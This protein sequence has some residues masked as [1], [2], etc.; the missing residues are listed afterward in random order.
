MMWNICLALV[1]FSLSVHPL[2]VSQHLTSRQESGYL[3]GHF[4]IKKHQTIMAP[5][6]FYLTWH[7]QLMIHAKWEYVQLS[8]G[9]LLDTEAKHAFPL[10]AGP[11]MD[12]S[13][14][15]VGFVGGLLFRESHFPPEGSTF[16]PR[17]FYST[18]DDFGP[19]KRGSYELLPLLGLSLSKQWGAFEVSS[20]VNHKLVNVS[21]GLKVF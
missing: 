20:L 3:K 1:S 5:K 16:G 18:G 9:Y 2:S 11:H 4:P 13:G 14:V 21:I 17:K 10:I 15:D 7:P 19:G 6:G 8:G 12:F